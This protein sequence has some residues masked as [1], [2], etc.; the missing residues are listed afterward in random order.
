MKT[1]QL[2]NNNDSYRLEIEDTK[3]TLVTTDE[4]D[5]K[6]YN[7]TTDNAISNSF[8]AGFVAD[9]F[10]RYPI[11]KDGMWL[12]AELDEIEDELFDAR[13]GYVTGDALNAMIKAG[14]TVHREKEIVVADDVYYR[15]TWDGL[16]WKTNDVVWMKPVAGE[17]R[18]NGGPLHNRN[19]IRM[20]NGFARIKNAL[21]KPAN[22]LIGF[23]PD[24][25]YQS[26]IVETL[27]LMA[28]GDME[29]ARKAYAAAAESNKS[30][31]VFNRTKEED[32]TLT[33]EEEVSVVKG[34][35]LVTMLL[36]EL[37]GTTCLLI[38]GGD[39][40][41]NGIPEPRVWYPQDGVAGR[42]YTTIQK[43]KAR[44]VVVRDKE[45]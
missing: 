24:D 42:F 17:Y 33:G 13:S 18:G 1:L 9:G 5:A 35:E 34:D 19:A 20:I 32:V 37:F 14:R 28:D 36:T 4:E 26:K 21:A 3:V 10:G 31:A 25:S 23:N 27:S 40:G 16:A 39:N 12:R 44:V 15:L 22:V 8:L 29:G 41:V 30:V 43:R 2:N 11:R 38:T 7:V 6:V 45:E